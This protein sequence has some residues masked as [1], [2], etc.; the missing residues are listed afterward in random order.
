[1]LI[2]AQNDKTYAELSFNIGPGG[3][4]LIPVEID[5]AQ[6]FGPSNQELWDAEYAANVESV[7]WP[8]R[9]PCE[10]EAVRSELSDYALPY[11]FITEF[12]RMEPT[13]RQ[14]VLDELADR[15][16]LWEEE[17]GVMFL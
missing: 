1:M 12:G 2:V 9:L 13:E 8:R 15:S 7:E 10:E 14:F 4:V 3:Q 17:S 16:E 6:D 11:D 5:Y